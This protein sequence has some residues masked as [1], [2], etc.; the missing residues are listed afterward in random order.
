[1]ETIERPPDVLRATCGSR[2]VLDLIADKWTV[3]V[4]CALDCDRVRF[5]EL[6]R[7]VQGIS[8]KMLTQTLRTMERN[9]LVTRTVY[10]TVPPHVDYDLTPLG[11]TLA[12]SVECLRRWAETHMTAVQEAQT[13]YDRRA[14]E[15]AQ[16]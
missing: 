14:A 2:A 12:D 3:L 8:Q 15:G 6:R 1:M 11:H 7:R 10:A 9:G 16:G 5:T 4:L 13:A